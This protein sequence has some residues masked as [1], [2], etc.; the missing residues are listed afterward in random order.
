MLFYS[1]LLSQSNIVNNFANKLLRIICQNIQYL[2]PYIKH[3]VLTFIYGYS[4]KIIKQPKTFELNKIIYEQN[5]KNLLIATRISKNNSSGS[6]LV[7][8]R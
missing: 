4:L 2:V 6:R 5:T 8:K 3:L 7:M 1:I